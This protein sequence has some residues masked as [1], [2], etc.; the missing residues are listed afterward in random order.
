MIGKDTVTFNLASS[1]DP[2]NLLLQ[3]NVAINKPG[4][5]ASFKSNCSDADERYLQCGIVVGTPPVA[6]MP[7]LGAGLEGFAYGNHR[8]EAIQCIQ[9]RPQSD[10]SSGNLLPFIITLP[11][12][13]C[14]ER[15]DG[16][17]G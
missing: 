14:E 7:G 11:G 4:Q 1:G 9:H 3:D 10:L 15:I 6:S 12:W 8:S 17:G 5:D 2:T 16:E 13:P